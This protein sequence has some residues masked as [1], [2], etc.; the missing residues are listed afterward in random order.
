MDQQKAAAKGHYEAEGAG[1]VELLLPVRRS[2]RVQP[3]RGGL[4][5]RRA[6]ELAARQAVARAS[7]RER[8][9]QA[10]RPHAPCRPRVVDEEPYAGAVTGRPGGYQDA[11]Q[12]PRA[13]R[14][15]VQREPVQDH[16]VSAGVSQSLRLAGGW[17]CLRSP[18][19]SL[20][21]QRTSPQRAGLPHAG[22]SAPRARRRSARAS[23]PGARARLPRT[24]R[25][26][27]WRPPATGYPA[28]R[29]LDQPANRDQRGGTT[30]L[31]GCYQ[32]T[33]N[34]G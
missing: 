22:A 13:R 27:P 32:N 8:E 3:L 10:G 24:S 17:S 23:T 16:E 12:T 25:A 4:A 21:Q 31:S 5:T 33:N 28:P 9:H 18:F 20:V 7:L 11:Q 2:G 29:G 14:Q 19:L 1:E 6:R 34:Y 26:V 30:E 15:S